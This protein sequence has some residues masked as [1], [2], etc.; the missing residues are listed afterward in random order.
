MYDLMY[1]KTQN[2]NDL[3]LKRVVLFK[4]GIGSFQKMGAINLA[5]NSHVKIS[6]KDAVINDLLKTFSI[7][8]QSGDLSISGVSYEAKETNQT[9]LLEDSE[10]N[11]PGQN[12]FLVLLQQLRGIPVRILRFEEEI[13]GKV[14]GTQAFTEAGEGEAAISKHYVIIASREQSNNIQT[15]KIDEITGLEILDPKIRKDFQFFLEIITNQNKQKKK[16]LTLFFKGTEASNYI[17]NFLQEVP[18]WKTTYRMFLS[19]DEKGKL[20]NTIKLQAWAII[21]NVLDED[22]EN[23][24][25]TLVSGLPVSFVYDSYSPAWK[26]RPIVER[27]TELGVKVVQFQQTKGMVEEE[28]PKM[29]RARERRRHEAP[30]A[31]PAPVASQPEAAPPPGSGFRAMDD[32]STAMMDVEIEEEPLMEEETESAFEASSEA[33]GGKGLAMKYRISHPV[34]VKRNNSSLI[35]L[36]NDEVS[37][38]IASVYNKEINPNNPIKTM[39]FKNG[40]FNLEKGPISVFLEGIFAGEAMLPFL[41]ATADAKVPFAVDQ[42][43]KVNFAQSSSSENY[44][45]ID[46]LNT[47]LRKYFSTKNSIY[48]IENLTEDQKE[49]TI[50]HLKSPGYK[51]YE[52]REP[53]EESKAKFSFKIMV[54]AKAK[55]EFVVKERRLQTSS[56]QTASINVEMIKKWRKLDL[57]AEAEAEFLEKRIAIQQKINQLRSDKSANEQKIR[58]INQDQERVRKNLQ[59]L[60]TAEADKRLREKYVKKMKKQEDIYESLKEEIKKISQQLNEQ[61]AKLIALD[62]D[63]IKYI[64]KERQK[65]KEKENKTTEDE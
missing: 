49:L 10:I 27:K 31:K 24:D 5:E 55:L 23:V 33:E 62:R 37:G 29:K 57:I 1:A 20:E 19:R 6:F 41:E 32:F 45:Q 54:E 30:R 48:E 59:S 58:E 26:P 34:Y 47:V 12:S 17:L 51:L 14:L 38:G 9:K 28:K 18:A 63:W 25:L 3:K 64:Q 8:R 53:D 42:G 16:T 61:H 15:I 7:L 65:K 56:I 13:S 60:R 22:W 36:L 2:L 35:P 43:L 50:E 52:T 40:N 44:H 46:V 11:L 4:S 21:D 39:E